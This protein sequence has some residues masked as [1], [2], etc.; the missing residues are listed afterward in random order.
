MKNKQE[1]V[2]HSKRHLFLFKTVRFI[3]KPVI[4]LIF[5]YHCKAEKGPDRPSFII[6]NHNCNLDPAFVTFGFS[7]HFYFVASEHAF[8]K[9]FPSKLLRFVF[10][11]I[12]ID[13]AR[14]DST[15]LR[16]MF[17]RIKAGH[18]ICIFAEGNRSF[19]G[20]TGDNVGIA[21]AKMVRLSGAD[22]I[23]FRFEGVYFT[24]PRW[25][26]TIRRGKMTGSVT[27][28]YS[29]EE[30]KAMTNEQVLE[31]IQRG[32]RE[33]AYDRQKENPTRY[34]G[35]KRAEDIETVLY[36]C[37]KCKKIGTIRSEGNNFSCECGMNATYTETGFL[38]G[39]PAGQLPF[40]TIT[41]WD[42]WQ[43]E[44]LAAMVNNAG[45]EPVCTDENQQLN[46]VQAAT[47]NTPVG[48]GRMS[49]SRTEF[50]CA[51]KTFPLKE[52]KQFAIVGQM[53]L[54]FSLKNGAQYEVCS[55]FPRSATKYL[56]IFNILQNEEQ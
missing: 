11:P 31:L 1:T 39:S 56:E 54:L 34:R 3:V 21:T 15:A 19:N 24:T 33:Y 52:I 55:P 4:K 32:I 28:R 53:T 41:D 42:K 23:T 26:K 18:S 47:E 7:G 29:A 2:K 44:Q 5:G 8:R 51:G 9:G 25:G 16:E 14:M 43:T 50:H 37:P 30:V 48:K 35:K 6:S 17:R 36:L 12:P 49:I 13:K 40:S 45:S 22:L 38:E 10:D 20:V 46:A 27:G